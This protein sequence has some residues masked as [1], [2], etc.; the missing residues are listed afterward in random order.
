MEEQRQ[1]RAR[2]RKIRVERWTYGIFGL[3]ERV[4]DSNNVDI[5]VYEAKSGVTMLGR[6]SWQEGLSIRSE[7]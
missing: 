1:N 5:T 3:D 2:F 6:L 4:I 7:G